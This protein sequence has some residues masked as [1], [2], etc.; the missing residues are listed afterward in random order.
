MG[1]HYQART[2]TSSAPTQ[3]QKSQFTAPPVVQPKW[4]RQKT[5]EL[6]DGSRTVDPLA[7]LKEAAQLQA[8]L[9]IGQPNDKYEQEADR[10]ARDVVQRLHTPII[11]AAEPGPTINL[12]SYVQRSSALT[13][14]E[15]SSELESSINRAKG[16]GQALDAGLQQSMGSAMGADFS[17][18]KVHTDSTSD[19]L[20]QSIQARAFTT[21]SDVFFKEGEYNPSSKGGQ[22]LIAHELTHVVQQGAAGAGVQRS[23]DIV[24]QRWLK[25]GKTGN[26]MNE[27][28]ALKHLTS[29]KIP[30]Q[31]AQITIDVAK[32]H[33]DPVQKA[34]L[35]RIGR[36]AMV[37]ANRIPE[38]NPIKIGSELK[39]YM[40]VP[41]HADAP[42]ATQDASGGYQGSRSFEFTEKVVQHK[43]IGEYIPEQ[44]LAKIIQTITEKHYA[45]KPLVPSYWVQD[46]VSN[47]EQFKSITHNGLRPVVTPASFGGAYPRPPVSPN[48]PL[49]RGTGLSPMQIYQQGG[50]RGWGIDDDL[51]FHTMTAQTNRRHSAYLSTTTIKTKAISFATN[52]KGYVYEINPMNLF[53]I[54]LTVLSRFPEEN[55]IAIPYIIPFDSITRI[56][57][58][59]LN[60]IEIQKL[61]MDGS[62]AFERCLQQIDAISGFAAAQQEK[63]S[64]DR[65]EGEFNIAKDDQDWGNMYD[66]LENNMDQ[67]DT[68]LG[69]LER[70]QR[71]ARRVPMNEMMLTDL[72][73]NVVHS[74]YDAMKESYEVSGQ[75]KGK[76]THKLY[77]KV[78][79][80]ERFNQVRLDDGSGSVRSL[81][82]KALSEMS[83][84]PEQQEQKAAFANL[85]GSWWVHCYAPQN[86]MVANSRSASNRV[87]LDEAT[88]M[89]ILMNEGA[90]SY[91]RAKKA[92]EETGS[93]KGSYE[94]ATVYTKILGMKK[95]SQLRLDDGSGA[96][97]AVNT[98]PLKEITDKNEKKAQKPAFV[99]LVKSWWLNCYAPNNTLVDL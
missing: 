56:Y 84:E 80:L 60:V 14:G 23:S 92:Y 52:N 54:D 57:D 7:R 82:I 90:T 1:R 42:W 76:E 21:G 44:E 46:D 11:N 45:V 12:K 75:L 97:R 49:Y 88:F 59:D 30:E 27:K 74:S 62:N 26:V 34:E 17:G 22:E 33:K 61:K 95:Y 31:L 79:K 99:E 70:Q 29:N 69:E 53:A 66:D 47:K 55:E 2:A 68:V 40:M 15:A 6:P 9:S 78:I 89:D 38:W 63:N 81:N 65:I 36:Q 25:D 96:V 43:D 83:G 87:P 73:E 20:N 5:S 85:V 19:Q 24:V 86:G 67:H 64:K 32:K 98:K 13:G 35:L 3:Q 41:G 51:Y 72:L 77:N 93:V 58:K 28:V 16:G 39:Y 18:V 50:F 71:L 10:V 94:F 37:L 91:K 48:K 4:R 8:K